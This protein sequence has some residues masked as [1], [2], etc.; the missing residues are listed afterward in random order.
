MIPFVASEDTMT[1]FLEATQ[2][3]S[4]YKCLLKTDVD[5]IMT[6]GVLSAKQQGPDQ[7]YIGLRETPEARLSV[8]HPFMTM[9]ISLRTVSCSWSFRRRALR[10]LPRSIRGR[11]VNFNPPL[12]KNPTGMSPRIG[13]RG[14]FGEIFHCKRSMDLAFL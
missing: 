7:G 13:E 8:R 11:I 14:I 3:L 10:T 6:T 12:S 5:R 1:R 2:G 4:L 9:S